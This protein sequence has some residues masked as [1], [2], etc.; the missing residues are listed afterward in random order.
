MYILQGVMK[1]FQKRGTTKAFLKHNL[2][3]T[4]LNKNYVV[5]S[6][7]SMYKVDPFNYFIM[8]NYVKRT[9]GRCML[10]VEYPRAPPKPS[11]RFIDRIILFFFN[12][13]R[14]RGHLPTKIKSIESPLLFLL[15]WNRK[16]FQRPQYS[17]IAFF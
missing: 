4:V 11:M 17:S 14:D 8:D 6:P 1:M 12:L 15:I 7:H 2:W 5:F 13:T 10:R 3:C 16:S 9:I